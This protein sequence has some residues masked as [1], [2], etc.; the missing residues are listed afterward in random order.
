MLLN[1]YA[2]ELVIQHNSFVI[3]FPY[4][5]RYLRLW[6]RS[7]QII[8]HYNTVPP[9]KNDDFNW[10]PK[11]E[12]L[13]VNLLLL[14]ELSSSF[15]ILISTWT[16]YMWE[17]RLI[18]LQNTEHIFQK[19]CTFHLKAPFQ[20]YLLCLLRTEIYLRRFFCVWSKSVPTLETL[21]RHCH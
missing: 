19:E 13:K 8:I 4:L 6:V 10:Q 18:W 12:I 2:V 16:E 17:V 15:A 11:P 9:P 14:S 7:K 20:S 5:L 21:S 3:S 1:A